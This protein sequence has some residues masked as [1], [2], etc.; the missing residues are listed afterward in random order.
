MKSKRGW[1]WLLSVISLPILFLALR[2]SFGGEAREEAEVALGDWQR[3]ARSPLGYA[4]LVVIAIVVV[5]AIVVLR[6]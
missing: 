5:G 4:I 2:G 1:W 6:H 3:L